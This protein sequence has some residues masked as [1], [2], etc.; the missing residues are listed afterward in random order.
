M[1]MKRSFLGFKIS[2]FFIYLG[3]AIVAIGWPMLLPAQE[4]V[5]DKPIHPPAIWFVAAPLTAT[6]LF[7]SGAPWP[8]TA[9]KVQVFKIYATYLGQAADSDLVS[10]FL[11][12]KQ[13]HM[14]LAI[15]FGILNADD[16][17]G[18]GI[19]GFAGGGIKFANA[20]SRRIKKLG[21]D[22][23]YIAMDEP[24]WNGH[25]R[26]G[27]H[28]C[29]WSAV[30][31]ASNAKLTIEAFRSVFP[32]VA[33]GDIEPIT[34]IGDSDLVQEYAGWEDAWQSI[35]G[36]PLAFFHADVVW[37]EKNI[38]LL[39][40]F[41]RMLSQK[42]IPFGIIYNG[43]INDI[44][45]KMW[46]DHAEQRFENY[47]N[48]LNPHPDQVI[49]QSW[50]PYP[51]QLLPETHANTFTNLVLRY[52]RA[53]TQFASVTKG[54]T[55]AGRL[56]DDSG[57]PVAGDSVTLESLEA[58]GGPY[59]QS[60]TGFI[61]K[62]AVKMLV[63]WRVNTECGCSGSADILVLPP[64]FESKGRIEQVDLAA[65]GIYPGDNHQPLRKP[66]SNGAIHISAS[67]AQQL[68]A[69]GGMINVEGGADF[70]FKVQF[71][72]N[73]ITS[74]AVTVN[75]I[76]FDNAG[77]EVLRNQLPLKPLWTVC[78]QSRTDSS[79]KF[80]VMA[81]PA[82]SR[83]GNAYRLV[84]RGNNSHRAVWQTIR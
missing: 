37:R 55:I 54:A 12:L 5:V 79:G 51:K 9:S 44:S 2:R 34:E 45:D 1:Q 26:S 53:R 61:P 40:K 82:V 31:I 69:N 68:I 18:S 21:G 16:P 81:P 15:E 41:G 75:I 8:I 32:K 27:L 22:L 17:C 59:V 70:S 78:G 33:F 49:F 62:S 66:V 47:E 73:N 76:F 24:F 83:D 19:E 42:S 29:K 72:V 52:F 64:Q 25:I 4:G 63:G 58:E 28:A 57:N 7:E 35:T 14:A 39:T 11:F 10:F 46:L 56:Q 80:Q 6:H 30:Q 38:P 23:A 3:F 67:P 77:R 13:H 74:D 48:G 36:E 60:I 43:E 50:N 20:F 71:S 84:F 65:L